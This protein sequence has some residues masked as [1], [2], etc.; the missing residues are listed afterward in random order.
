MIASSKRHS[1]SRW[2]RSSVG[3]LT[4]A[5]WVP[6]LA[7]AATP[8]AGSL[9]P[10]GGTLNW[11]GS[12]VGGAFPGETAEGVPCEEGVNCDTFTL[13]VLG[14]KADWQNKMIRI[15]LNWTLPVND[16]DLYIHKDNNEGLMVG[17]SGGGAPVTTEG[18]S[19]DP[20]RTGTGIY[21]VHVVYFAV[22]PL[23]DQYKGT[24][25][26]VAR[27]SDGSRPAIYLKGGVDFS[28][29]QAVLCPVAVADGEPSSRCDSQGNYYVAGI[30]GVPAGCDLWHFDLNP[31]S[32]TF[33]PFLRNAQYRGQPD[34]FTQEEAYQ[35][36]ADGGGDVDLAVGFGN[37]PGGVPT[38]AFTSL[39]AANISTAR[40]TDRGAT[41]ELNPAGN[42]TGGVP[43]DD[44]QWIEFYGSDTVYLLYRTLEPAIAMVQRSNDGGLTFGAAV[45]IG[46]IGQVG[47]M[48]VDQKDGTVLVAGS[49]G[50]VAVGTP[51]TPG[52]EP[53][54][55]VTYQAASDPFD[56]ANI[57]V[58]PRIADD[59]TFYLTYSNGYNVY[60]K[61]SSDR[62]KTWSSP[63]RV[64]AGPESVTG[65]LPAIETGPE[66]GSVVVAWYG[67]TE[68]WNSFDAEWHVYMAQTFNATSNMPTFRQSR[69]SDHV[70]HSAV[71]STGGLLGA[72]N[73]NLL[74]YFQVCFDPQGAALIAYTDDHADF[75]GHTFVSRQVSGM[76]ATRKKL[77]KQVEGSG[78]PAPPPFSEDGSQVVDF[79]NDPAIGL[80]IVT[81]VELGLD[82]RSIKYSSEVGSDGKLRI[83]A[84][85]KVGDLSRRGPNMAWRMH[86]AVN[87]PYAGLNSTGRYSNALMEKGD[88]FYLRAAMSTD[89]VA[90][91]QWGT[92]VRDRGGSIVTTQRGTATGS[93][94]NA[95]NTVTVTIPAE[96]LNAFV[97]KGPPIGSGTVLSGLLGDAR[98][99][100][101]TGGVW[102]QTRLGLEYR[103]P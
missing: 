61:H 101:T 18:A 79:A 33:D 6:F 11:T 65:L 31:D 38:L 45:T 80:L 87:A 32:S 55:Y 39:V 94:D 8:P 59:G 36:G 26:I 21:T 14:T 19:I 17:T 89:N 100:N 37:G 93:F 51:T 78:L 95:T 27:P 10:L 22:V 46:E 60:L 20:S 16:Y 91:Y 35:V 81:P 76:G 82:I 48:D 47:G 86:F 63:V 68:S 74:D 50:M 85:M 40:S 9:S 25:S 12:A 57:F 43:G 2:L 90:I 75:N 54:S 66:P 28:A 1:G 69:V 30:R 102:D 24:A 44:R 4:V 49:S 58:V 88:L 67:T 92:A 73:R 15:D 3:L 83:S 96:Q 99:T 41:F 72:E 103:I 7:L 23:V 34:S 42:A 97:A 71:I 64:N 62:G 29:N 56:V 70:I 84:A 5:L 53:T 52:A 13:N 77:R 98:T